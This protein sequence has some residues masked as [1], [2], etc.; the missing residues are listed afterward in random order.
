M[1]ENIIFRKGNKVILRPILEEDLPSFLI[2]LNDPEVSRFIG[3]PI[4][5]SFEQEK[6]WFLNL[7]KDSGKI[8]LAIVDAE[9]N[10]LIG[11]I[12]VHNI[13]CISAIGT[14][15]TIIGNKDYWGKGYGTE[16]KM[17]FLEFLFHQ[18]NLRKIYSEVIGFNE[19]SIKYSLKCG[20]VQEAI[21]PKHYYKDGQYWDKVVLA[22][23]REQWEER[24]EEFSKNFIK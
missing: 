15:G 24:W 2:W 20:Y 5:I 4:P 3:K 12:D 11:N 17:L 7:S 1:K 6:E 9:K 23:Y 16:A 21:F 10:L 22:L 13:N 18:L 14:T 8:N 19:R